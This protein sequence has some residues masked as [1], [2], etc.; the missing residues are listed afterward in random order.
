[1]HVV[2]RWERGTA[3]RTYDEQRVE[4]S[5]ACG[6][7]RGEVSSAC[8]EQRGKTVQRGAAMHVNEHMRGNSACGGAVR[9]CDELRGKMW[10]GS[11]V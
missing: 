8:D 2:S 4:G 1:V 10:E 5:G 6:E 3:V 7:Q 9:A 11:S